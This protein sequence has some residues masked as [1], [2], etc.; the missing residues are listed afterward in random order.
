MKQIFKA[1]NMIRQCD[2]RAFWLRIIYVLILNALPLLNL[3]I[4]KFLVDSV[5]NGTYPVVMGVELN[6]LTALGIFCA[7]S[8]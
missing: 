7:I 6:T 5:T 3:Y 1:L 4:L 2:S 8:L